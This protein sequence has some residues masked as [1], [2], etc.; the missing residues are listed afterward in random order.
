MCDALHVTVVESLSPD[1]LLSGSTS[2]SLAILHSVGRGR[3]TLLHHIHRDYSR[4]PE[5]D[6]PSIMTISSCS[7][8]GSSDSDPSTS[9]SYTKIS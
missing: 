6:D 1:C 2:V 3:I 8:A 4:K 7:Y 9:M 5:T